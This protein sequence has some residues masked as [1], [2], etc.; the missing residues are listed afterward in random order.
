[1]VLVRHFNYRPPIRSIIVIALNNTMFSKK[2]KFFPTTY[3]EKMTAL[4]LSVLLYI[5]TSVY[6]SVVPFSLYFRDS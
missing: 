4:V 1:M 3:D 2:K 5:C 6:T